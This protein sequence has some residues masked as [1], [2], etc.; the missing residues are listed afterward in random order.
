MKSKIII[1]IISIIAGLA[2]GYFYLR[3]YEFHGTV[4]QSPDPSY[5][6]ILTSANGEVSPSNYLGKIVLIYF[7]YTSCPDICPTT[8]AHIARAMSEL[9]KKSANIQVIMISLDPERDTPEVLANYVAHFDPSFIG[10]TGTKTQIEKTASLYG[11][12]YEKSGG[13][14]AMG[15]TIDHTSILQ[16]IDRK[17]YLK[18]VLPSDM[19]AEAIAADLNYMLKH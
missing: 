10:V 5:D 17:G 12:Y 2:T 4:I 9:G 1:V 15:Y 13:I 16:V 19:T 7:G 11:I 8:L 18:L 3:P 6:F 14:S